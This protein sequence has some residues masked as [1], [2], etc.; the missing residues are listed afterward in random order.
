MLIVGVAAVIAVIS[1][2]EPGGCRTPAGCIVSAPDSATFV[3][4]RPGRAAD[5][6]I[7]VDA[8]GSA[9][10]VGLDGRPRWRVAT[11]SAEPPR[12]LAAGDLSDDGVTDYVL[13]LVRPVAPARRCGRQELKVT[14]FVIV[15]GRTGR[16]ST[17]SPPQEDVCWHKPTFSYPTQQWAPG[18]VYIT[19]YT[20]ARRGAELV[21]VPYYAKDGAVWNLAE[22]GRWQ[23]VRAGASDTFPWPSTPRFDQAYA[24]ANPTPCSVPVPG[25]P[26][27]V[28]DSH[29][30]N[31]VTLPGGAGFFA[32]TSAR[33]V[34]Y[35]PDLSP[36][37]DTTWFPGGVQANG[38]RNYGLVE[39]YRVDGRTFVDLVGGC[40]VLARQ[41]AMLP[42]QTPSTADAEC[43]LARHVER[44]AI[45]GSQIARRESVYYGYA[46]I[47]GTMEGRVEYPAH[48]RAPLGGRSTSWTAYNLLRGGAWSAQV[49][50]GP[51][52]TS[53]IDL[54][55][56]Y[57]WDTIRDGSQGAALLATRM[58][59]GQTVPGWEFDVLRWDGSTFRSVQHVDGEV[60]AL[61]GSPSSSSVHTSERSLFGALLHG[62]DLLVVGSDGRRRLVAISAGARP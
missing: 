11:A 24:A 60:P 53:A 58:K 12:V 55:G 49:L 3:A 21:A 26:C 5:A 51:M 20:P 31:G 43:G 48:A 62:R 8:D 44:F 54:Q 23:R 25:G 9:S 35:R 1:L 27:Y 2:R 18:T 32:L 42:G 33:A 45:D 10:L 61:V 16:T 56:W 36:T 52:T 40:S 19:D 57:V 46:G 39:A 28:E 6:T 7:E 15:D 59:P 47:Q 30:A 37:S 29:V 50:Q 41:R 4:S 17:V 14:S 38:G 34:I 22:S 13:G